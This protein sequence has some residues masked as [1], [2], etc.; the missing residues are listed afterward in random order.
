MEGDEMEG[1][2]NAMM[3]NNEKMKTENKN[4]RE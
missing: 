2:K 4:K 3:S 1:D